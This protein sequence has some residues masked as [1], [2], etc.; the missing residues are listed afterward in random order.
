MNVK[1]Q[2]FLVLG[3]SKSGYFVT[4]LLLEK[5]ANCYLY[6]D[7]KS[8]KVDSAIEEVI[9]LGAKRISR[10]EVD[11]ILPIIDVLIISPGVKI[12]HE[13]AVKAKKR[14][15]RIMSEFEFAFLSLS[16]NFTFFTPFLVKNLEK[17]VALTSF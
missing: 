8:P 17:L 12:N 10:N 14:G 6:E 2:T 11:E 3:I 13:I 4:K 9:S 15:I 7:F 1:V 5:N 16:L